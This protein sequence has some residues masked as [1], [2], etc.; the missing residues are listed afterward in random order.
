MAKKLTPKQEKFCQTYIETGNASEAYRQAYNT[1]NMKPET[2]SVKASELLKNGKITVRVEALQSAHQKR[3]DV[4]VDSLTVELD[5]ARIAALKSDQNSAAVGA[6]MGKAKLH[7]LIND[8]HEHT[9]KD[10]GPIET[11]NVSDLEFARRLAFLLEKG[12]NE[13]DV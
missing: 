5:E 9:G 4:T 8:K 12:A 11:K 1:E 6:T 7:G 10:G 13:N 3:H 2:V